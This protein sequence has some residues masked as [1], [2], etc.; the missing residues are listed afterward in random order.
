MNPV[1]KA[2]WYIESHLAHELS[3]DEIAAGAEISR[4]HLTRAFG[5]ATGRSPM[6]Y[7][8]ARRLTRAAQSL[9]RGAPDILAVALEA[10]YSSHEA[11]TRSF[12]D[13]FDCTPESVRDSRSLNHL[14]LVEPIRLEESVSDRI[15]PVRFEHHGTLLVAGIGRRYTCESS[16]GIPAQWNEFLPQFGHVT[17]Q[18]G[19]VAYGVRCNTDSEGAFDYVSG[20]EVPGFAQLPGT[21]T[22][23]RIPAQ[24]YAVFA[25]TAHV[26]A[27]RS[28]WITIWTQWLPKSGHE[29]VDAPDFERYGD[30]FDSQTGLG[31]FEIWLPIKG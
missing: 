23:I 7:A 10:G 21:L 20:V 29:V 9:A 3:L 24:K 28:T 22:R 1:G 18:V 26:A 19:H 12:R 8:R 13:Q 15:A 2:L 14:S 16:A 27:I 6:R 4:F 25:H 31:G 30:A 5:E 11:F 17:G